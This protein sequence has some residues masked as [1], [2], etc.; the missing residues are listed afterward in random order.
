MTVSVSLVSS[1]LAQSWA[2]RL[3]SRLNQE[4]ITLS[5]D[6]LREELAQMWGAEDWRALM[7][8]PA[9]KEQRPDTEPLRLPGI[10]A[11]VKQLHRRLAT[12]GHRLPLTRLQTLWA[13]A[14]G[15]S[16]WPALQN[17]LPH[18]NQPRS[19]AARQS[20]LWPH[21]RGT[22]TLTEF[23]LSPWS[24]DIQDRIWLLGKYWVDGR[25]SPARWKRFWPSITQT[26]RSLTAALGKWGLFD[27]LLPIGKG[28]RQPAIP[29][30]AA[31][32]HDELDQVL[33]AFHQHVVPQEDAWSALALLQAQV[34][35]VLRVPEAAFPELIDLATGQ[36][37]QQWAPFG[38]TERENACRDIVARHA[39]AVAAHPSFHLVDQ[40][41]HAV[42]EQMF[43][44]RC[45]CMG[46]G[47]EDLT[48]PLDMEL[49]WVDNERTPEGL[50]ANWKMRVAQ[51]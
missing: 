47:Y 22:F 14:L 8:R 40:W 18:L 43:R 39:P 2:D 33:L 1:P 45:E 4:G 31:R 51:H 30:L 50:W 44:Q 25:T 5:L 17:Y 7:V 37:R 9:G 16:G 3:W 28:Q 38:W 48:W 32:L 46:Q 10:K 15:C 20:P 6:E 19:A 34:P 13:H 12:I 24:Q 26:E 27:G 49:H 35:A 41:V 29:P 11:W 36:G 23:D 42:L 21:L